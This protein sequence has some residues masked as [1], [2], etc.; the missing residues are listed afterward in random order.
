MKKLK[1]NQSRPTDR[2]VLDIDLNIISNTDRSNRKDDRSSNKITCSLEPRSN[3][4]WLSF[5]RRWTVASEDVIDYG[6]GKESRL[7]QLKRSETETKNWS[8]SS[9]DSSQS[10]TRF[11]QLV[12]LPSASKTPLI[13]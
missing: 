7:D 8:T 3:R 1:I 4:L 2:H 5:G 11:C 6:I 9:D 13:M 10:H 12:S